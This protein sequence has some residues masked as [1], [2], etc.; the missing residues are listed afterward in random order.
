MYKEDKNMSKPKKTLIVAVVMTLVVGCLAGLTITMWGMYSELTTSRETIAKLEKDLDETREDCEKKVSSA[1]KKINEAE[2]D[3]KR[4]RADAKKV[5]EKLIAIK[6]GTYETG[7]GDSSS[8]TVSTPVST[9]TP[10]PAP[11]VTEE[12]VAS[13][14]EAG[15]EFSDGKCYRD[16]AGIFT[17]YGMEMIIHSKGDGTYDIIIQDT[18]PGAHGMNYMSATGRWENDVLSYSNGYRS[19]SDGGEYEIIAT[20]CTGTIRHD[21]GGGMIWSDSMGGADIGPFTWKS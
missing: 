2:D 3:T 14:G 5:R 10:T 13:I 12:P 4:A 17:Y 21:D 8:E 15:N 1:E 20:D 11:V 6:N 7:E 9:T 19:H 16:H 18:V